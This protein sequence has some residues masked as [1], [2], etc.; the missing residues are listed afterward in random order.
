MKLRCDENVTISELRLE[1]R[2]FLK[3]RDWEKYHNPK[4][5]AEAICVE[6]AELLE[7]FR[8]QSPAEA[9]KSVKE[10]KKRTRVEE[11]LADVMI[12]CLN[13]ANALKIDLT[14]TVL[15]KIES[16]RQKYPADLYYGK[17]HL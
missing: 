4:D 12:Y 9:E 7:L 15:S 14:K 11:E 16:N 10:K 5:L 1:T 13:M 8:W 6:A 17:A 2:T 3:E